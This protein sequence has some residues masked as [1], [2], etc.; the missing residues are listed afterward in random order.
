MLL[1]VFSTRPFGE[2]GRNHL[3]S[4]A[5]SLL[6]FFQNT[7]IT[8]TTTTA[9]TAAT[10]TAATAA[11]ATAAAAAATAATNLG[12]E[13]QRRA[14]SEKRISEKIFQTRIQEGKQQENKPF[15]ERN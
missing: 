7:P 11:A 3:A 14:K 1:Q 8:T 9:A 10:T 5:R 4:L 13:A 6:P 15:N 2:N 12:G